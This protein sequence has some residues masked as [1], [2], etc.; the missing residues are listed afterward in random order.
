MHENSPPDSVYALD[1]SGLQAPGL[2]FYGGWR[3][4]EL[5]VMGAQKTIDAVTADSRS[6][7][8]SAGCLSAS[9]L[10]MTLEAG[11]DGASL[12]VTE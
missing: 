4:S 7:G 3:G 11:G 12:I 8:S 10:S 2:S 1:L 6:I 5:V 9:L